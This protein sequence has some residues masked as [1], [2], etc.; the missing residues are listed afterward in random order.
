MNNLKKVKT[1]LCLLIIFFLWQIV[2][3]NAIADSTYTIYF[4]SYSAETNINNFGSLKKEFD[5]YLS[6]HGPYQLQPFSE[7][8]TF[9]NF[10]SDK[11]DGVFLISSWHYKMLKATLPLKPVLVGVSKGKSIQKKI[12]STKKDIQVRADLSSQTIASA[13]S[14]EYTRNILRQI[15]GDEENIVESIRILTV[16]KEIDALMAVSFGMAKGAL[17]TESSLDKLADMNPKQYEML[18][19]LAESEETLFPIVALPDSADD[20]VKALIIVLEEMGKNPE[21][22]QKLKM[23]GLDGWKKLEASEKEVLNK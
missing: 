5:T 16:P 18:H 11:K 7:R 10:I 19:K 6:K 14:E 2:I 17:T 15:F 12:L 22:Q 4:Y 20:K 9:E 3:P 1:T 21:G 23:L 8:E 13:G